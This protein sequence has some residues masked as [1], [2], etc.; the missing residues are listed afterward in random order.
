MR[1]SGIIEVPAIEKWTLLIGAPHIVP[2]RHYRPNRQG[3]DYQIG[4]NSYHGTP[5]QDA[6][7]AIGLLPLPENLRTRMNEAA[8]R[9]RLVPG[10]ADGFFIN[11]LFHDSERQFQTRVDELTKGL[12][13]E[14]N[15]RMVESLFRTVFSPDDFTFEQKLNLF[16]YF[17]A[18]IVRQVGSEYLEKTTDIVKESHG[19]SIWDHSWGDHKYLVREMCGLKEWKRWPT[20]EWSEP[21]GPVHQR[22]NAAIKGWVEAQSAIRNMAGYDWRPLDFIFGEHLQTLVQLKTAALNAE[23]KVAYDSFMCEY[24]NFLEN[25]EKTLRLGGAMRNNVITLDSML[26]EK[27]HVYICVYDTGGGVRF[28]QSVGDVVEIGKEVGKAL[29]TLPFRL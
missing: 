18:E 1:D 7:A 13:P 8:P 23:L 16:D 14:K 19:Y 27:F 3:T 15:E 26:P 29:L 2:Y 24:R 21:M 9:V 25:I 6:F 17:A 22:V 4:F 20:S 10:D 28:A 12:K 11:Y 5:I